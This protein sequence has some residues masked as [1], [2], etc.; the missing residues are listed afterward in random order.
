MNVGIWNEASKYNFSSIHH[1]GVYWAI[2]R[3]GMIPRRIFIFGA[4]TR[5]RFKSANFDPEFH[6]KLKTKHYMRD[7]LGHYFTLF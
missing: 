4:E 7:F 1:T 5:N 6:H 3:S 2:G